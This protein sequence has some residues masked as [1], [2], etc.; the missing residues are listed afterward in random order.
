MIPKRK[1]YGDDHDQ[2]RET[3]RRFLETEFLPHADRW[4]RDGIVPRAFWRR[5][6]EMGLLCPSVPGEYGGAGCNFLFNAV[7]SEEM[8][9]TGYMFPSF[10]VH[11]DINAFYLLHYGSEALKR[12]WL[13][14]MVSGEAISA[15][16]MSEPGAGS[17]LQ[18]VRTRAKR[19]GDDFVVTGSKTFIT[20]GQNADF[21]ILVCRTNDRPGAKGI[22]LLLVE[23]D[24]AGFVRGRNLDKIGHKG[25]DTSELM[26]DDVRV[27]ASNLIGEEG[28]GFAYLMQQLPQERLSVGFSAMA[29]AQKAFDLARDYTRTRTA[30]GAPLAA[31]QAV[32]HKLAE[33][34]TEI[35]VGWAF[36]DQCLGKA[37]AGELTPSEAAMS[38]LWLT[39]MQGRVVD[40][41]LQLHGGYGFMSEYPISRLYVDARVQRIYG[42][43]SEIM[44]EIISRGL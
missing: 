9:F 11:S 31:M 19:D 42:G 27:P 28:S 22:S 33:V 32:R 43:T 21:V 41:C 34:S 2:F 44:K 6:G 24:R 37:L 7:V 5:A 18:S 17:D 12:R 40:A 36:L 16:A 10:S 38:K 25:A 4:E 15:I 8:A 23:G 20:N 13:P 35:T 30:F 1:I 14:R 26:F 3:V 39:E 29:G